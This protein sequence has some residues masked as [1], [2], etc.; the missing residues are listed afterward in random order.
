MISIRSVPNLVSLHVD[1][2]QCDDRCTSTAR[3]MNESAFVRTTCQPTSNNN[4]D[5]STRSY[6]C[7]TTTKDIMT[8][9]H[10]GMSKNSLRSSCHRRIRSIKHMMKQK[11][12]EQMKIEEEIRTNIELARERILFNDTSCSYKANRI[13]AILAMKRIHALEVTLEHIKVSLREL[14]KLRKRLESHHPDVEWTDSSHHDD[15]ETSSSSLSE[16]AR[17]I[18]L[19]QTKITKNMNPK[20]NKTYT[21]DELIHELNRRL[22]R[23]EL[24]DVA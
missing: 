3:P 14:R 10:D 12:K 2:R 1:Y 23:Q 16:C 18:V 13:V 7:N 4:L 5:T 8:S 19:E 17:V 24:N 9:S 6:N 22:L 11:R 20:N 21:D 15:Y